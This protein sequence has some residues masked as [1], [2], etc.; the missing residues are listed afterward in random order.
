M[1]DLANY[2]ALETLKDG[3]PAEIR[4]FRADDRA[5][6]E[7]AVGRA[8]VKSLYLR[9]FAVKRSF[10]EKER[11]FFLNVDFTKHVALIAW[12]ADATSKKALIG[13]GRYVVVQPGQAEVAFMVLDPY[14]GQG[15]GSML[16]RHLVIIAQAAGLHELIAE[17]LPENVSML[18]V[19]KNSGLAMT[20]IRDGEVVH[21][22]LSLNSIAK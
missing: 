21:V 14:Q 22:T 18:K 7:A 17:V 19:L 2:S 8:S 11:E 5:E 6:L 15:V 9:F 10:T 20:T 3:R 4:S 13:G 12:T 16:M 1:L